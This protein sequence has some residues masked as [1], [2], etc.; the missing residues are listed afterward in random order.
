MRDRVLIL[1][2]IWNTAKELAMAMIEQSEL[3]LELA[4]EIESTADKIINSHSDP[5]VEARTRDLSKDM[6]LNRL[7]RNKISSKYE[8][9]LDEYEEYICTK[10]V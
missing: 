1:T 3:C 4:R 5:N 2:E 10:G 7:K 8:K 6:D 9:L